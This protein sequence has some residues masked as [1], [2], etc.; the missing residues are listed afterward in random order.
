MSDDGKP[1]ELNLRARRI[2]NV[3]NAHD[4]LR[5]IDKMESNPEED[6]I[7]IFDLSSE[8]AYKH[9]LRQVC[10]STMACL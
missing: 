7:I 8:E 5:K 3:T 6:T 10:S 1:F 4:E 9:I 2:Y